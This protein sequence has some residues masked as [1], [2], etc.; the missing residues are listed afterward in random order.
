[1]GDR[2][3]HTEQEKTERALRESEAR[4]RS[5]VTN[6]RDAV[7]CFECAEPI[8]ITLP[9]AEQF[10]RLLEAQLIECNLPYARLRGAA[11]PSDL[12]GQ[13]LSALNRGS[14]EV[15]R[16]L[17]QRMSEADYILEGALVV[18][19]GADG[20]ERTAVARVQGVVEDGGLLRVW[21]SFAD[22]T[23]SLR[24]ER[25]KRELEQQ[26][27]HA[28]KMDSIGALAG[29][30]AHDFNNVL[31][32]I[33][34]T[35]ELALRGATPAQA[36]LLEEMQAAA[37]RG[38]GLTRRLLT[39]AHKQ[40]AAQRRVVLDD[41][42]DELLP[43]VRRLIPS[44]IVVAFTARAGASV[45]ADP[46]QVEQVVM[47]LVLNARDA[48]G[49]TAGRIEVA[50]ELAQLDEK[51][52]RAAPWLQA[53]EF[54]KLS[55]TDSGTGIAPELVDR[56]FEPFFTTKV[57]GQGTGL[58]LSI[59]YGIVRQHGGLVRVSSPPGRGACF[60]VYLPCAAGHTV[61]PPAPDGAR[62]AL[63]DEHILFAE[64]DPA[65]RLAVTRV[66]ESAGYRVHAAADGQEAV[67]LF[68][69]AP[70]TFDLALLDVVMPKLTGGQVFAQL[71]ARRPDFRVI[72]SSGYSAGALDAATLAEPLVRHLVKPY[73][74][75]ALLAAV[76]ELLDIPS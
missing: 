7:W 4:F 9:L 47:N 1:M 18:Q 50:T 53:R 64:D 55:V 65:V 40:T 61:R 37:L 76:R 51:T 63:G 38:A 58:G 41:L 70:S 11:S 60:E 27:R 42:L 59:V 54:L 72:F 33:S 44:S 67:R 6:T 29:G 17:F 35:A 22:V 45:L 43:M 21:G 14:L 3:T 36:A 62:A 15:L 16:D 71:R 49:L 39:F 19:R 30:M 32:V 5:F 2:R 34:T 52:L 10:E 13:P 68:L 48:I 28:Q 25:E 24:S 69:A 66:L 46:G 75:G 56:I 74:S 73:D 23:E 26:L 57:V 8:A 12:V 31:M 20:N